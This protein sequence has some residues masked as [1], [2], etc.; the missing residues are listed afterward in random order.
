MLCGL[1]NFK[2]GGLYGKGMLVRVDYVLV[3]RIYGWMVYKKDVNEVCVEL[4]IRKMFF[5][6]VIIF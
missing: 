5:I 3:V 4:I 6:F 1:G 2:I